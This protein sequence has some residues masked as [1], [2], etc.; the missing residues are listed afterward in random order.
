MGNQKYKFKHAQKAERPLI[1]L[2]YDK[3]QDYKL[4]ALLDRFRRSW[5]KSISGSDIALF[6]NAK[7]YIEGGHLTVLLSRDGQKV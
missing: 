2:D 1:N 3:L 6:D 7:K 5:K 4:R